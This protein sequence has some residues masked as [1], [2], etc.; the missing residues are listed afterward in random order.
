MSRKLKSSMALAALIALTAASAPPAVRFLAYPALAQGSDAPAFPA[1]VEVPNGTEIQINGSPSM[2]QLNTALA[3]RFEAQF[4][5]TAVNTAYDGTDT[6]LQAVLNGEIDLAAIGRSL[7]AQEQEQGL[8]EVPVARHK[9][10]IITGA[11]NPFNGGLTVEQ[12]AQIF[13]GEITDWSQVGGEP[14]AIRFVDRPESS[15]IRQ[16]FQRYPSFQEA[17]FTTG[18]NAEQV[19]EDSTQAVIAA[20]GND[21]ISYAIAD[22]VTGNPGLRIVPLYDVL[23]DDQRYPFSQPLN[24]VYRE[25]ANPAV[26]AFLGYATDSNNQQVVEET[27]VA[28]ATAVVPFVAPVPEAAAPETDT[29]AETTAPT[30]STPVAQAE[31]DTEPDAAATTTERNRVPWWWLLLIPILGGLLWWLLGRDR[32]S[33]SGA[34]VPATTP[35]AGV[36]PVEAD[37]SRLILTPR[38]CKDAYAYW[39]VPETVLDRLHRRGGRDLKLRL[40][41]VTDLEAGQPPHNTQEFSCDATMPDL[42]LPI[43]VDNRDYAAELGYITTDGDWLSIARSAPVRVPACQP[44]ADL[45]PKNVS[46]TQAALSDSGSMGRSS[47]AISGTVAAGAMAGAA[48]AKTRPPAPAS[49][50]PPDGSRIILVPRD[51]NHAYAYWELS[52][53]RKAAL[54]KLGGRNL[55]LRVYDVTDIDSNTQPVHSVRQYDC[56]EQTFDL[57]VP[58]DETDRDYIAELGYVTDDGNWRK[59]A[60]SEAVRVPSTP[61]ASPP[62]KTK[63]APAVETSKTGTVGA[64][65]AIGAAIAGGVAGQAIGA[66]APTRQVPDRNRPATAE[67]STA[68]PPAPEPSCRIILVPRSPEQAYAY[69]EVS[70]HFKEEAKQ[71]GA[72]HFTLQIHDVTDIDVDYQ[73]PHSTQ[74]YVCAKDAQDKHVAI[75]ASDRD[76]IAELGYYTDDDR[77]R[78]IIRSFHVHVPSNFSSL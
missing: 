18:V 11:D 17:P 66:N 49:V 69:W 68:S 32:G 74:E 5:G 77:W 48:R 56:D 40:Y 6:A 23:P 44:D 3:E 25:E 64:A 8:V 76:Y 52:A 33:A 57:H 70:D 19:S 21:G 28:D 12:F 24:Y 60:R 61:A 29:T 65:Q 36:L 13:R 35:A 50:S 15:D 16:A 59:I 67:G 14:G 62:P 38:N 73:P 51:A 9:I 26:Q 42:H 2:E 31:P 30:D 63:P 41:D 22:Q 20:L 75:P 7:T 43:A 54:Q 46:S 53:D 71:Q 58:I 55:A 47:G 37:D 1:P 10:A 78:R 72:K 34:V 39:E 27:R 4:P 45:T